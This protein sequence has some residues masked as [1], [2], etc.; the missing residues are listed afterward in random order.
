MEMRGQLHTWPVLEKELRYPSYKEAGW[1]GH[2]TV[3]EVLGKEN[4]YKNSYQ[5]YCG[6]VYYKCICSRTVVLDKGMEFI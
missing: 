1:L 6:K 2:G 3:L 5:V 4:R